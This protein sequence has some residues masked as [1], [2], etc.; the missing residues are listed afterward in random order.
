MGVAGMTG[1]YRQD[2]ICAA[3]SNR[4]GALA[5]A[6]CDDGDAFHDQRSHFSSRHR[7][8]LTRSPI[9]LMP[10]KARRPRVT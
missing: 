6:W 9:C 7:D 1:A 2:K 3:F 10:I 4:R 5:G 8:A